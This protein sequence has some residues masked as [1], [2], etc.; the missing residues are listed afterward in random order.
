VAEYIRQNG[1]DLSS[2]PNDYHFIKTVFQLMPVCFGVESKIRIE[3]FF[4][5]GMA[6]KKVQLVNSLIT[7][8]KAKTFDSN[9]RRDSQSRVKSVTFRQEDS[10]ATTHADERRSLH[11]PQTEVN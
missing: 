11:R 3:D 7:A 10:I 6:E 9:A 1:F 4:V 5:T 2:Q 8:V